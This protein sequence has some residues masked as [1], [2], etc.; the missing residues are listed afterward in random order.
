MQD[1]DGQTEGNFL[2]GIRIGRGLLPLLLLFSLSCL[3][4][5]SAQRKP[6]PEEI[7]AKER[8]EARRQTKPQSRETEEESGTFKRRE[9]IY[10]EG[11][12]LQKPK[13]PKSEP[14]PP[15]TPA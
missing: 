4:A 5:T 6:T 9:R 10:Q 8:E 2:A 15:L 12:L 13:A 11:P 7:M 3:T 14:L 1:S